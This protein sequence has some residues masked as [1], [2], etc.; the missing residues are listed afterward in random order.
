[1]NNYLNEFKAKASDVKFNWVMKLFANT[2]EDAVERGLFL[3]RGNDEVNGLPAD[4]VPVNCHISSTY[5]DSH[6]YR[7]YLVIDSYNA[8]V[9]LRVCPAM[10]GSGYDEFAYV[11]DAAK[12]NT[13]EA[14]KIIEEFNYRME[15]FKVD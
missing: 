3:G 8:V 13:V 11:Q 1:M 2:E 4:S 12:M 5:K 9:R 7:W 10:T 6:N 14:T 15:I